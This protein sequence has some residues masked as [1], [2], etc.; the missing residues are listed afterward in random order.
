MRIVSE[1]SE[2]DLARLR[3][4][5]DARRAVSELTANL[6]RITRGAGKPD[7]IA[8]HLSALAT[9]MQEHWDAAKFWPYDEL[10]DELRCDNREWLPEW[11]MRT[12]DEELERL[13]ATEE[14]IAGALQIVASRLLGQ[15]TQETAGDHQLLAGV[16]RI[17]ALRRGQDR[18]ASAA[19]R[20]P[21]SVKPKRKP[22]TKKASTKRKL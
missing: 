8:R 19:A 18:R 14:I 13:D 12:S 2:Q 16:N 7:E 9:A 6:L 17:L 15:R 21:R 20:A 22:R 11:R 3:A 1:N 4:E 10:A 5:G